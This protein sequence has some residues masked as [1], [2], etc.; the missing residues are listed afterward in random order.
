MGNSIREQGSGKQHPKSFLVNLPIVN[1]FF[2]WLASLIKATEADQ[3]NAGVYLG[4][5]GRD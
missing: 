1:G 4:G 3:E 2:R 5:E